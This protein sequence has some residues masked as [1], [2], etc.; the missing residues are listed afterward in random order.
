MH[1]Y[2]E[3]RYVSIDCYTCGDEGNPGAAVHAFLAQV[4]F[5]TVESFNMKRGDQG[6]P[7][8]ASV[9]T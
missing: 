8:G 3:H 1:T 2:P 6:S 7:E 5:R 9:E 4:D